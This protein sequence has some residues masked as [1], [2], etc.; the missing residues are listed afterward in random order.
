MTAARADGRFR[1]AAVRSCLLSGAE[2]VGFVV[3]VVPASLRGSPVG[4][5]SE[6][7]S[8]WNLPRGDG[9]G[10]CAVASCS[11]RT[12]PMSH[13]AFATLGH[14]SA[15]ADAMTVGGGVWTGSKCVAPAAN[16]QDLGSSPPALLG[17]LFSAS[18]S[19]WRRSSRR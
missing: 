14:A 17:Y 10:H 16:A 12:T 6:R 15:T 8:R 7:H 4:S 2:I 11:W 13:S 1:T 3:A 19:I 9:A 18:I 5:D